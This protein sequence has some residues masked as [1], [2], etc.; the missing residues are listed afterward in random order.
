MSAQSTFINA[1]LLFNLLAI[2]VVSAQPAVS[3]TFGC[4][5]SKQMLPNP[6]LPNTCNC[7][8][9]FPTSNGSL[10][11]YLTCSLAASDLTIVFAKGL[12]IMSTDGLLYVDSKV[13]SSVGT[14]YFGGYKSGVAGSLVNATVVYTLSAPTPAPTTTT[15][16]TTTS[17]STMPTTTTACSCRGIPLSGA[18][19][20]RTMVANQRVC[21]NFLDLF[22]VNSLEIYTPYTNPKMTMMPFYKV[23][24]SFGLQFV[25]T[26]LNGMWQSGFQC[27]PNPMR[28]TEFQYFKTYF[29]GHPLASPTIRP[30]CTDHYMPNLNTTITRT[31]IYN[32]TWKISTFTACTK[33]LTCTEC[34]SNCCCS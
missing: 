19:R 29:T 33:V 13:S 17:T 25:D 21:D 2:N 11:Y 6:T 31:S 26:V 18:C 7:L 12:L 5:V 15:T 24:P 3:N 28:D 34:A 1:F 4:L 8:L 32:A 27:T 16:T 20:D 14:W 23:F 22:N 10:T 30:T 9:G